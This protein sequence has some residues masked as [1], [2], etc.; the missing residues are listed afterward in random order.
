VIGDL[1]EAIRRLRH[2]MPKA[3]EG[4]VA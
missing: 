2:A 4:L 3:K 1:N